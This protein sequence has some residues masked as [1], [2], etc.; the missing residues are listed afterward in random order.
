[1]GWCSGTEIFDTVVSD[2]LSSTLQEHSKVNMIVNL[3]NALQDNDWD[4]ETDSK[5]YKHYVVNIAF[6]KV[7]PEWFDVDDDLSFAIDALTRSNNQLERSELDSND[8]V[9][10]A[11]QAIESALKV[12]KENGN[13]TTT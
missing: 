12:L 1:M 3:I 8:K 9:R 5:Y 10:Y 6:R 13:E 4:C 2:I 7:R 11:K